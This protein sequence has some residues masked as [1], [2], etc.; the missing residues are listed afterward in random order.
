MNTPKIDI[1]GAEVSTKYGM[2]GG[3]LG[4]IFGY[5][6]SAEVVLFVSLLVTIVGFFTNYFFRKRKDNREK[7]AFR[8]EALIKKA[9]LRALEEE[10]ERKRLIHEKYL[11]SLGDINSG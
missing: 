4:S 11:A 9:R 10:E 1:I 7:E 5:A 3:A 2:L 6:S 8:L